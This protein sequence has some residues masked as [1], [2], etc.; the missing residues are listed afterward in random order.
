MNGGVI[1][2]TPQKVKTVE[3]I[4]AKLSSS[5]CIVLTDFRGLN[6]SQMTTLRRKLTEA[7]VDYKVYKNTLIKIAADNAG[8]RG[9]EPYLEGPTAVAF[10]SDDPVAPAK[11]L[12]AFAR[13]SKILKV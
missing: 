4:Q 10:S 12:A 2:S 7:G 13:E 5:S 8:I 6:V 1:V 11:I 3:E 9:L